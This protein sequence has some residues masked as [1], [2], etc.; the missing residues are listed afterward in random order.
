METHQKTQNGPASPAENRAVDTPPDS[1][2]QTIQNADLSTLALLSGRRVP[3]Y[4]D[5]QG[6]VLLNPN[7]GVSP[8]RVFLCTIPKSGSYLFGALLEAMGLTRAGIAITMNG[9]GDRRFATKN[10]LISAD[11]SQKIGIPAQDAVSLIGCGQFAHGQIDC[12]WAMHQYLRDTKVVFTYRDLR[13]VLVSHMR[14][15][16]RSYKGTSSTNEWR[17][18]DDSSEKF[19]AYLNDIGRDFLLSKCYPVIGWF[20]HSNTLSVS[21][22]RIY[23]DYGREEQLAA[24][25]Q[26]ADYCGASLTRQTAIS[27]LKSTIGVQTFTW[28]GARSSWKS[29]WSAEADEF[30]ISLG[31]REINSLLG[32]SSSEEDLGNI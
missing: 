7:R 25:G 3:F 18:M 4:L 23:G 6:T 1:V 20:F 12:N 26:I 32:Y 31:A 15:V 17:D 9:F 10:E 2:R 22:E 27:V 5:D 28:S 8:H 30:F 29:V 21:F 16:A 24:I 13:D 14:W 11:R 19:L